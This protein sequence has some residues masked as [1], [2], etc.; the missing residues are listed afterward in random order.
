MCA[1]L[2]NS[3][4]DHF[5]CL[6]AGVEVPASAR[7]RFTSKAAVALG[8]GQFSRTTLAWAK[9]D[10]GLTFHEKIVEAGNAATGV[11]V[12]GLAWSAYHLTDGF[13]PTKIARLVAGESRG[14]LKALTGSRLWVECP[15]G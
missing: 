9:L 11:W 3:T 6:T 14:A 2:C 13:V 8:A 15:G 4:T 1:M 12:R 5:P 10:D 7:G